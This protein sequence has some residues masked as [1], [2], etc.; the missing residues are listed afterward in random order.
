MSIKRNG[1]RKQ[2]LRSSGTEDAGRA[3][4]KRVSQQSRPSV[5]L[6]IVSFMTSFID[7]MVEST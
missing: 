4:D 3:G 6:R 7:E 5:P 1:S 2:H